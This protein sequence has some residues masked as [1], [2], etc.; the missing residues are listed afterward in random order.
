ML[1]NKIII[2]SGP[3]AVG[4]NAV[5]DGVK[6]LIPELEETISCTTR[7]IRPGE[8]DAVHYYF[9]NKK[10]FEEKIKNDEFLEYF[11]VHDMYYGTP[12]S[13][14]TRIEK[15]KKI[16]LL[17]IDVKGALELKKRN[18]NAVLIFIK[19]DSW[20]I[21]EKRLQKRNT[22][23]EELKTRLKS[24]KNELIQAELYDYQVINYTGEIK[25][26]IEEMTKIIKKEA[27]IACNP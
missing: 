15:D 25:K 19:P 13:E 4:K 10:E 16:P 3:S 6:K 27:G 8:K 20:E 2:I 22:D 17:V 18:L 24:A 7:N 14:I 23:A 1:K 9:L 5:I 11:K 12:K 21:L 26:T